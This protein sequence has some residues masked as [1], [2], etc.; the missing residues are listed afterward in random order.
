MKRH[1]LLAMLSLAFA[2][3]VRAQVNTDDGFNTTDD[4]QFSADGYQQNR[5]FGRSD[6]VQSQ[7][8]EIPRGLK[9]WTIDDRFGDRTDAIPDTLSE[10]FM[11]S[12][13][14]T[15]YHGE[16]NTLGNVGSPR[17]NRIYI[18]RQAPSNFAFLDPYDFFIVQPSQFKFT[19]TYSPITVIDYNTCGDRTN[20]EDHFRALFAVNAGKRW[21]F[22]FKF[23]YIYG[24]GYY[25]S[26]STSHFN[27]TMW[28]TY[29]GD[30]YQ[31]HLLMSTNHQKIAENGGITNDAYISHPERFNETYSAEEV[32]TIFER[33]WNRNDNQHV[34]FNHRYSLG[35]NRKVPMTKEEIEA[36]KFALKSAA[37]KKEQDALARAKKEA[38]KNGDDF[39][40]EEYKAE[41]KRKAEMA[42]PDNSK[43][44]V[45]KSDTVWMKDEYVPVTSFVHTIQFDNYRRIYEAYETPDSFYLSDYYTPTT[46]TGDSIYDK[47]TCW[48]LRNTAGIALLEG[49]NKWAKAGLKAFATYTMRH[50]T[51][52]KIGDD[53]LMR[54]SG[55][56]ERELSVGAQLLKT[57]GR[58][59]HYDVSG[60]FWIGNGKTGQFHVD[61]NADLNVPLFGDTLQVLANAFI[62]RDEPLF[63][64]N[65][66]HS[67]H[68]WWDN[69][70]DAQFHTRIMGELSLKKLGTRLRVSYD[71]IKDYIYLA[72]QYNLVE[73]GTDYQI[74][75]YQVGMHQHS[76]AISLITAQLRQ[77]LTFW[78]L[79]HWDNEFTFQKSSNDDVLP[80]P[81]LNVYSNLYLRF[82]IAR[83][84]KCDLGTDVRYFTK[85][86]APEYS[87]YMG[88][89][90]V[91][92]NAS[93]RVKVGNYP[94]V[95][96][97]ANFLLQH[98]R[99]FIM[100]SHVN[101][102]NGDYFF[103]PHYPLNERIL[104][105][106]LS[107]NFFN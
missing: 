11:N 98:T 38:E 97:Y 66:Y 17:I 30:R 41:L 57:Q 2:L 87:P 25:T 80:V 75:K 96:V 1:F 65:T 29:L 35:F 32:P 49:F 74:H 16:Y 100:L 7:H 69:D 47:S 64:E 50:F 27:Y 23:D 14:T 37:E 79:L 62:H 105:F 3:G 60:E 63:L 15:G 44:D 102:S 5:N 85:Y 40:E 4:G 77:K 10:M 33:N 93:S 103:T 13:F 61:A 6:S 86:Y 101:S 83:V 19:S 94:V 54:L 55:Y 73:N 43:S 90:A 12:I 56:N 36:R 67:R 22:G 76:G 82:K 34:F 70:F 91:Q 78:N 99:F 89:F 24:R 59:V 106:G 42:R 53:N 84:L 88:Q 51:L 31:A 18:D 92:E 107:W 52:P 95:N 21:G 45:Q 68:A 71:N 104:R 20:G 9:V 81:A 39:D 28:G 26:Q 46:F 48:Q 58:V 72:H 8:K